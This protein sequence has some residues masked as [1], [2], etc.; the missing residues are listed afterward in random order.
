VCVCECLCVG[1]KV[2]RRIR[3]FNNSVMR[4]VFA[5]NRDEVQAEGGRWLNEETYDL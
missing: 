1:L 3:V 5:P 2:G 4:K